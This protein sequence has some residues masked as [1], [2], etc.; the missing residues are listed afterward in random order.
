MLSSPCS[1]VPSEHDINSNNEPGGEGVI[2]RW[3]PPAGLQDLEAGRGRGRACGGGKAP[4]GGGGESPDCQ[5]L[6]CCLEAA[7]ANNPELLLGFQNF[8]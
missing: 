8:L 4:S 2:S 3:A 7:A 1:T 6:A 5:H